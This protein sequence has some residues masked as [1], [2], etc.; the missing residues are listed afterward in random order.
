M[1]VLC[2]GQASSGT[3]GDVSLDSP[4]CEI[5]FVVPP[6]PDV[7]SSSRHTCHIHLLLNYGPLTEKSSWGKNLLC[8]DITTTQS[9]RCAPYEPLKCA[10]VI[11]PACSVA[12]LQG[13]ES[14]E[15]N[16]WEGMEIGHW[17]GGLTEEEPSLFC[18]LLSS[19]RYLLLGLS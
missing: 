5:Y 6:C 4:F 17:H 11:L 13:L 8:R 19:V 15:F 16:G 3:E 1:Y 10:R 2:Y 7:L 18:L 14:Q 9:C 12:S